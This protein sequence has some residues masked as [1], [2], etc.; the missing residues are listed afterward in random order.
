MKYLDE[1]QQV[2][3]VAVAD[4]V[5]G[6]RWYG[7]AVFAH[8]LLRGFHHH[9]DNAFYDVVN[10]GEVALAVA[11]V[12]DLN[13]LALDELVGEAEVGHV[14]TTCRAIDSEESEASAGD[15]VELAVGMGHEL[16]ALLGSSIEGD[17]VVHL[18][19]GAVGNFLV[20][21]IDAG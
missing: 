3:G 5:H 20:A 7:K 6:I 19:V 1:V 11:V 10:I 15:V 16:V 21:A 4:V 2:L 12:E 18:V 17:G 14:G 9:T 8:L 13:L